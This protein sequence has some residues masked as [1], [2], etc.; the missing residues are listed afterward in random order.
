MLESIDQRTLI[1][2]AVV[3]VVVIALIIFAVVMNNLKK[4]RLE[5]DAKV[6]FF[7]T[8]RDELRS[9]ALESELAR[10]RLS[11]KGRVLTEKYTDW[12]NRFEET[13]EQITV[14]ATNKLTL[15]EDYIQSSQ[16]KM[17]RELEPEIS[18]L[19]QN[20]TDE[21]QSI[22]T[23]LKT[24]VEDDSKVRTRQTQIDEEY[25]DILAT[26][27]ELV[28]PSELRKEITAKQDE[29]DQYI[30]Q[31]NQ[32]LDESEYELA[33]G[34]QKSYTAAINELEKMTTTYPKFIKILSESVVQPTDAIDRKHRIMQGDYILDQYNV[35]E[36]I[37][38]FRT[39]YEE[40]IEL[41][42]LMNLKQ[43]DVLTIEVSAEIEELETYL[44][45][46][47]LN[48]NSVLK[49]VPELKKLIGDAKVKTGLV[50]TDWN[51]LQRFYDEA[52]FEGKKIER[53]QERLDEVVENFGAIERQYNHSTISYG[54]QKREIES[55]VRDLHALN[56]HLTDF[57]DIVERLRKDENEAKMELNH[58]SQL[59]RF[60]VRKVSRAN[61]P[62]VPKEFEDSKKLSNDLLKD[63]ETE[64][65]NLPLN[66]DRLSSLLEKCETEV[67]AF[68][69]DASKMVKTF[70]LSQKA[71][72]F[73]NRYRNSSAAI[74]SE[75][76]K[77]E[78]NFL[79]GFY[80][81]SLETTLSVIAQ[82]DMDM[83][84][85]LVNYYEE[86]IVVSK[87]ALEQE[88]AEETQQEE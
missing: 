53:L 71:I 20:A 27:E 11:E 51:E 34:V 9:S 41:L 26:A 78:F 86:K 52:T 62:E 31:I 25:Q 82:K 7:E 22:E 3:G 30:D 37:Q 85:K 59:Y 55:F 12:L 73:A 19:L 36:K 29:V 38:N 54:A 33:K 14:D 77:S 58:L 56:Q 16:Y 21:F 24:F 60:T 45:T 35:D 49:Y 64:L 61:M 69:E 5:M 44:A 83:Y 88:V 72:V 6:V 87:D 81:K 10:L 68:Y 17:A 23:E 76:A 18:T 74:D 47:E 42:R 80:G 79:N 8:K 4:R 65:A 2:V 40:L 50:I 46:E 66:I 15:F 63:L 57:E 1:I 39:Q 13:N 28:L 75:L 84:N 48:R 67:V 70:N 43:L 32:H